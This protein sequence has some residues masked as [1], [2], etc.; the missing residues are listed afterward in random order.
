M[1][2]REPCAVLLHAR[3]TRVGWPLVSVLAPL[4]V[5]VLL[6]NRYFISSCVFHE[7]RV[8]ECMGEL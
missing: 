2:G 4:S 6:H 3:A 8:T 7:Q 1:L 5:N